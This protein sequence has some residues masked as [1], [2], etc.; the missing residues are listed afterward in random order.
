MTYYQDYTYKRLN[1][2]PVK[3]SLQSRIRAISEA[4]LNRFPQGIETMLDLGSADGLLAEG[5]VKTVRHIQ[6]VYALDLDF[7]LLRGN[8]FRAIQ[9]DCCRMPFAENRFD[10]ITAAALIEHLPDPNLFLKECKRV[11]RPGGALALTCPAPFFDWLATHIGY[12]KNVGHLA[13]YGLVDLRKLCRQAGMKIVW[14][15]KFMITPI[16]I[17]GHQSIENICR[18]LGLSCLML[19]QVIVATKPIT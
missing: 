1:Y 12:L 8:P 4:A 5:V 10:L 18:K 6:T 3:F 17:K 15:K 14:Q 19:N 2:A 11:L 13:R 7:D 16:H 9:G